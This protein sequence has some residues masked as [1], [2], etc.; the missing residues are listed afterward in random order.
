MHRAHANASASQF[1]SVFG[2]SVGLELSVLPGDADVSI[3]FNTTEARRELLH[4]QAF[5]ELNGKLHTRVGRLAAHSLMPRPITLP[6][7]FSII[8]ALAKPPVLECWPFRTCTGLMPPLALRLRWFQ[9]AD[10]KDR[11]AW[12]TCRVAVQ[13][14][15]DCFRRRGRCHVSTAAGSEQLSKNTAAWRVAKWLH[16]QCRKCPQNHAFAFQMRRD[17]QQDSDSS[18][19]HFLCRCSGANT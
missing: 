9:C 4:L 18:P 3:T 14:K 1:P 8:T 5:S 10:G 6:V 2:C 11:I 13:S 16:N 12:C 19:V 17:S 7:C 15:V